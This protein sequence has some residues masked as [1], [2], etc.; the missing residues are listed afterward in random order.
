MSR[1]DDLIDHLCPKGV[2]FRELGTL[3]KR[4]KGTPMTAARMKLI[5][6]SGGSIRVFAGGQTI[7][8]V[9]ED[10]VPAKDVVR[11]PSII[12]KSRGNI[13]FAYYDR[14]FTHKNELWSYSINDPCADP[15]FV[16]Y[17]LLT[18]AAGLQEI[19]RATSV[20][21]PQ[22][23]VKDTDTLRIPLPP[24]EVQREIV[25][26]LDHFTQLEAELNVELMAR[27]RQRLAF[28]RLLP[29]A[30]HNEDQSS[31][32]KHIR[33]GEVAS[34]YVEPFRVQDDTMYRSL[35]VK[36]YGEGV[37]AR[38]PK[39]G[40]AIKGTVL[41]AVKPGYLVY[42]RMFVTEGS[43]A[44]VPPELA[45]GVVSNEFP[46]YE[47]DRSRILPEWLLLYLQDEYTLKR[48]AAEVTGVERGSTKSRMRWK[49][50]QFEAFQIALPSLSVQREM[51]RIVGTVAALESAL[52]EEL[53]ARRKQ[54]EYYRN[55]LLTFEEAVT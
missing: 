9:S 36:W 17:Y 6:A 38:E 4:N 2:D 44:I 26:I 45:N 11:V 50:G 15:K 41:Y 40:N 30:A 47:L 55:K 13:G 22:L 31:D 10:A 42:N 23:G 37:L 5:G 34:Q 24:V 12:V 21:I 7:A 53:T 3:G 46:V 49:E 52:R 14:P 32:V 18:Q 25:R 19:A 48:I 28:T 27:R 51:V 33:L 39:L 29:G 8:D 35:G 16:Y 20:K 1:V 54:F 43:F